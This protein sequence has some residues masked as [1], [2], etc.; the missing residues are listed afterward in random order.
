MSASMWVTASSSTPPTPAAP[1]LAK[2]VDLYI[3]NVRKGMTV[4]DVAFVNDE[5]KEEFL[6]TQQ[7]RLAKKSRSKK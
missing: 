7:S 4:E 2:A 6:R 3:Q 1:S 5:R